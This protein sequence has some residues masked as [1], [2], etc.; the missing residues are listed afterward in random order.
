MSERVTCLFSMYSSGN[1]NGRVVEVQKL[2]K[3]DCIIFV[4]LADASKLQVFLFVIFNLL[5]HIGWETWKFGVDS[6]G[7][8]TPY[9]YVHFPQ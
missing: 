5:D 6:F 9:S 1:F 8:P 2:P 7:L 4:G 3:K